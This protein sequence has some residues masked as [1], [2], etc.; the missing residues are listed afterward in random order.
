MK[1]KFKTIGPSWAH[2]PKV[3][4]ITVLAKSDDIDFVSF[5]G[6]FDSTSFCKQSIEEFINPKVPI[7]W[8]KQVHGN[9]VLKL[10]DDAAVEADAAFTNTSKVVC[11]VRTA[12]CLPIV[13]SN[14]NGSKVGIVHAGWR[15]LEKGIIEKLL[16]RF[17]EVPENILVWIGPGIAQKSYEVGPEVEE[18]FTKISDAYKVAFMPSKDNRFLADLYKIAKIQLQNLGINLN[19]VSGAEWDTYTDLDLHSSRR[20]GKLSGRMATLVWIED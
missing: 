3:R 7:H 9:L 6:N 15:G 2:I 1:S 20:N 17:D 19:N 5:A 4:A 16:L 12:D 18:A 8:L 10:P 14:M 13:F 11:A